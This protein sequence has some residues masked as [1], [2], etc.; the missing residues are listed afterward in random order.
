MKVTFFQKTFIELLSFSQKAIRAIIDF[1]QCFK[2]ETL[3]Y[4][5]GEGIEKKHQFK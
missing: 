2:I 5:W 4:E 1:I 3:T